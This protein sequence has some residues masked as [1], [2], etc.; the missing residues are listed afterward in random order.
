MKRFGLVGMVV[1]SVLALMPA[2]AATQTGTYALGFGRLIVT[3]PAGG[4]SIGGYSFTVTSGDPSKVEIDDAS[5]PGQ[6]IVICQEAGAAEAASGSCQDGAT[7]QLPGDD[8]V[9][10]LCATGAPQN[11]A[12]KFTSHG[13]N[14]FAVFVYLVDV[15]TLEPMCPGVGTTFTITLTH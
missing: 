3:P 8:R 10:K 11:V 5:G 1:A 7:G 6:A 14:T 9:Q 15:T 4:V 2:H 12:E 13:T